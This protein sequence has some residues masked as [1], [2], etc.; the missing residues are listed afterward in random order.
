M[1][2]HL[3]Q[4]ATDVS[5]LYDMVS[6]LFLRTEVGEGG[7]FRIGMLLAALFFNFG[8]SCSVGMACTTRK[9]GKIS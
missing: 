8:F 3:V 5:R 7:L 1:D 4:Y 9:Q 6:F 2:A